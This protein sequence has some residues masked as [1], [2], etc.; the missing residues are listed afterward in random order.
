MKK[1]IQKAMTKAVTIGLS[2]SMLFPNFALAAPLDEDDPKSPE[3]SAQTGGAVEE[4]MEPEP[5]P[6]EEPRSLEELKALNCVTLDANGTVL[7]VREDPE[8]ALTREE[9]RLLFSASAGT[10]VALAGINRS[11]T[12]Y[13]AL[14]I[15]EATAETASGLH[16]SRN[17]FHREL[18]ALLGAE[19]SAEVDEPSGADIQMLICSGYSFHQ[20]KSA[21][22][23]A[24]VL[25]Y[26]LEELCAAKVAELTATE[27]CDANGID[28]EYA[29]MA[30]RLGVPY[31]IVETYLQEHGGDALSLSEQFY[32]AVYSLRASPTVAPSAEGQS[33]EVYT[34]RAAP[35]A[36][37][38][39]TGSVVYTPEQ[40]L[41]DPFSYRKI[42]NS[43]INL[44]T[45]N[46]IYSET[47]LSIPGV[48]GLDLNIVRRY[49]STAALVQEPMGYSNGAYDG[50][51]TLQV[52]YRGYVSEDD[53]TYTQ[54]MD[55]TQYSIWETSVQNEVAAAAATTYPT[56]DYEYVAGLYQ[57]R[58]AATAD[59]TY[60]ASNRNGDFVYV[61]LEPAI[62]GVGRFNDA[63][64]N[65]TIPYS[66]T[67]DEYGLGHGWRLGFSAIESYF[68]GIGNGRRQRL[69]LADG[70]RY[71]VDFASS[72]SGI[73]DYDLD[74][75]RLEHSGNGYAGASYTLFY[76]D[77]KREYFDANGRNIAIVDR[78]GN[79]IR[80]A[81]T[82]A[83]SNQ[84]VVSQIKITDTLGNTILYKDE[85][86]DASVTSYISGLKT[87]R[88]RYNSKWTLSLNGAVVRTYY[89]YTN[90]TA[91]TGYA[92]FLQ[93]VDNELGEH[94]QVAMSADK[95]TFNCFTDSPSTNDG[96]MIRAG[97]GGIIYPTGMERSFTRSSTVSA[98]NRERFGMAGYRQF[99]RLTEV[100]ETYDV[101]ALDAECTQSAQ[102]FL[103]GD[104]TGYYDY[105]PENGTF[106]TTRMD[107]QKKLSSTGGYKLWNT[108]V[109]DYTYRT[110]GELV[111]EEVTAYTPAQDELV[112]DLD[113]AGSPQGLTISRA[114]G[115]NED[116]LTT[117]IEVR[118]FNPGTSTS[119][120]D[121]YRYTYDKKGNVLTE[122]AP[123]GRKTT[124]TYSPAYNLP[125]TKSYPQ[126]ASTTIVETN[127]LTSDGKSVAAATVTVNGA[128][129]SK[130]A[131]LYDAKGRVTETRGYLDASHYTQLQFVYGNGAQVTEAKTLGVK[132]ATGTLVSG[133]PGYGAGIVVQK[134]G[135]NARGWPVAQTDGSGNKTT[136][137]YDAAG[138]ITKV[139]EAD[140]AATAYA[141]NVAGNTLTLTDPRGNKT[142]Y[143]YDPF[144]NQTEVFDPVSNGA[145]VKRAYDSRGRMYLE[146]VHSSSGPDKVTYY[147]YDSQDRLIET[148]IRNANGSNTAL[149]R[150]TYQD[151][152]R[153]STHTVLGDAAAPT[154]VSTAYQDNMG[155]T[156]KAGRLLNG[157]EYADTYAYD[158]L[159]NCI[160]T[161]TAYTTS[162][163]GAFT[164]Q[165]AYDYAGRPTQV[166]NA[167]G[168]TV[169]YGYDWQGNKVSATDAKGVTALSAYDALGRLVQTTQP[170]EGTASAITRYGYDGAGNMTYL[171]T[172][173]SLPSA[174]LHFGRTEYVY[175]NRNFLSQVK[176]YVSDTVANVTQYAYDSAG[177]LVK[178]TS[179]K[180]AVTTYT[181][182]RFGNQLTMTDPLGKTETMTY[183]VNGNMLTKTERNGNVLTYSYDSRGR[184]TR[185]AATTLGGRGNAVSIFTYT[186]SGQKRTESNGSATST[187]QYDALGR[188]VSVAEGTAVKA[189]SYNIGDLRTAFILTVSGAQALNNAYT[190]DALGRMTQVSGSGVS[191]SYAYDANGNRSAV[192]YNNGLQETYAYNKA[193]LV[194][195]VVNR[196]GNAVLSQFDYAYDLAGRQVG[197]TDHTGAA[198]AYTY[199]GQGQLTGE[200]RMQN[201]AEGFQRTYTYDADGNRATMGVNGA[202]TAYRTNTANRLTYVTPESGASYGY[203]YDFSGNTRSGG[204]LDNGLTYQYDGFDRQTSAMTT[205]MNA[206]YTYA[207]SGLR[208]SK[209]VDGATT[210]YIW[211]GDQLV[212]EHRE[213]A[214]SVPHETSLSPIYQWT[215]P[216]WGYSVVTPSIGL[217]PVRTYWV[218]VNDQV[219]ECS[220]DTVLC[221][222]PDLAPDGN[223]PPPIPI[224][225]DDPST[226]PVYIEDP[227]T[228]IGH[229]DPDFYIYDG[230]PEYEYK[231]KA[232]IIYVA[233]QTLELYDENPAE[234]L[235]IVSK[236]YKYIRG[237]NLVASTDGTETNYYLYN[238]HGDV[239]QTTDAAGTVK[240][241]YDYDAF[242][243][244]L[245]D[246]VNDL[247]RF[248]YC[249][250]YLDKETGTI[251][252]R[253]RN[254]D[255][256]IGRMTTE[257]TVRSTQS[258]LPNHAV[259][260]DPMG[261]NLYTYCRN[262]PIRYTDPTGN[263]WMDT[264]LGW[265]DGMWDR[266]SKNWVVSDTSIVPPHRVDDETDYQL[267]RNVGY[268]TTEFW[269]THDFVFDASASA[270]AS[271]I[272]SNI[273]VV[274][275]NSTLDAALEEL[276]LTFGI[277]YIL[278]NDS[279]Y[280]ALY[281]HIGTG[282]GAYVSVLPVDL[283]F[284][285]GVVNN[286]PT[287]SSYA[288]PFVDISANMLG[289]IDYCY[290]PNGA[291]A[292]SLTIATSPGVGVRADYYELVWSDTSGHSY[293]AIFYDNTSGG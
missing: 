132:D 91:T 6:P 204:A 9:V 252:L 101:P 149:E 166:T 219:Y 285:I 64:Y 201:G 122:T 230:S 278:A 280:D 183:D 116:H 136:I 40:V 287:P 82:Y 272:L 177:N 216:D 127:T 247:N 236:D 39:S 61:R 8:T 165:T 221:G 248:R 27:E 49:D 24:G 181:Y 225:P 211:D 218:K 196:K 254:Y 72:A 129:F 189:Y 159:G 291:S 155:N 175:N 255:P 292:T 110:N 170:F 138:R 266:I 86:I 240:R 263:S 164:T 271:E 7:A 270:P 44:A 26:T 198:T 194:T 199:D 126:N 128:I 10:R 50:Y 153:K 220:S 93:V 124:C 186:L 264:F 282:G 250:E 231:N 16:G 288:G 195:Q 59:T 193:N 108:N 162:L 293:W 103:I 37:P 63:F 56:M 171:L 241:T 200:H 34:L 205:R 182:D 94:T 156:V 279:N 267:A 259:I 71:E 109:I 243:V 81:Y 184:L 265:F 42:G 113:D 185:C 106:V 137:T 4:W 18:G 38:L 167:L 210:T 157:T 213:E 15:T 14:G 188:V 146:T 134:T 20:A 173:D 80:L 67:V 148:G 227:V 48:N 112:N 197:K 268:D 98:K 274:V 161:K 269:G 83:G 178:T 143:K 46:Y 87:T 76:A 41:D 60:A 92:R 226:I 62:V 31:R 84:T 233:G 253:A 54:V 43:D 35:E 144:G 73:L 147:Y 5:A 224:D 1:E 99:I 242:G 25:G 74:D 36:V 111:R 105:L 3:T 32:S 179:P 11:E 65:E 13:E 75:L 228:Y 66:Y 223:N 130:T 100:K 2:V 19:T 78:Y 69:Y 276:S 85:K 145:L 202:V 158:L 172:A 245:N 141:Y 174:A 117:S 238:A 135:Y 89:S 277:S 55:I 234:T 187:F 68:A 125:L 95:R 29:A 51:A 232:V 257:D 208:S 258:M 229:Q 151:W 119:V 281:T 237:L 214:I 262:D 150:Y 53:V 45:G 260:S 169:R 168:Q 140:G 284:S 21:I 123:N 152:L 244:E 79:A 206:S 163:K 57:A 90:P 192:A 286:A 256:V 97:L 70:R 96:S 290:Y 23:A 77:G 58:R 104:A 142:I 115:Y 30:V 246:V 22:V 118:H 261:L 283:S 47:D 212:W 139:T 180:N 107:R 131:Y 102:T 217:E 17:V 203:N 33:R 120:S 215:M 88:G 160:Q 275:T 133:S 12:T 289:G 207:P 239:V 235:Q 249:G 52:P 222:L 176:A 251:Y 28:P 154:M 209:T 273:G 114:Y 121:T 190:Y 191:A